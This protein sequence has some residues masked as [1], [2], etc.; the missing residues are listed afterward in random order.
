MLIFYT[1]QSKNLYTLV[2]ATVIFGVNA[3]MINGDGSFSLV[4]QLKLSHAL[5][6]SCWLMVVLGVQV[7]RQQRST[8]TSP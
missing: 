7:N 2:A 1:S 6:D 4:D 8:P 3:N 5:N